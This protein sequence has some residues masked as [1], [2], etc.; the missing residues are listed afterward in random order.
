MCVRRLHSWGVIT[1]LAIGVVVLIASF[2]TLPFAVL[3][4]RFG[5]FQPPG[6]LE[7]AVARGVTEL[8][9]S[10]QP[11]LPTLLVELASYCRTWHAIKVA[12][13]VLLLSALVLLAVGLWQRYL[14]SA[15]RTTAALAV[16][17]T[18]ATVLALLA[19]VLLIANI[20]ATAVP[21]VALLQVLPVPDSMP[22]PGTSAQ[23]LAVLLEPSQLD[24]HAPVLWLLVA[25]VERYQWVLAASCAPIVI[26]LSLLSVWSWRRAAAGHGRARS[27]ATVLGIVTML[28][29]LIL[30]GVTVVAVIAALHPLE[31][32][33]DLL[34]G[35]GHR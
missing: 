29:A 15:A 28:W 34:G 5:A 10:G 8:W 11:Q 20:Q 3:G 23:I 22:T 7:D 4:H 1:G 17:A 25:Q 18:V 16:G 35:A 19:V 26:A 14:C 33:V 24:T 2:N 6:A 13:C 31:T 21:L 27:M 30:S 12:I 9:R 32:L